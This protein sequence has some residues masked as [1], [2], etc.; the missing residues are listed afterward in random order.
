MSIPRAFLIGIPSV[1]IVYYFSF[2]FIPT[3]TTSTTPALAVG[4]SLTAN[5]GTISIRQDDGSFQDIG[6]IEGDASYQE[7]MKRLSPPSAEHPCPPY[8]D[9]D[10]MWGDQTRQFRRKLRKAIG[11]P[12]SADVGVIATMIKQL[13]ALANAPSTAIISYPALPGLRHEDVSDAASYLGVRIP[14]GNHR[15]PPREV[16]AAYAGHGM[17]L[18]ES[19]DDEEKCRKE[20]LELPVRE[21]LLVEYTEVALLLHASVMREAYDLGDSVSDTAISF[22]LGSSSESSTN[23]DGTEIRDFIVPLLRKRYDHSPRPPKEITVIM[24]G[25]PGSVNSPGV[26]KG[27]KNAL[28][29]LDL[30]AKILTSEPDFIAARGAA[31][32]AWRALSLKTTRGPEE[33]R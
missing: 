22:D 14:E 23:D 33:L 17:G 10:E 13:L 27:V 25:S 3:A 26:Q 6:R 15:F 31:E 5:H 12:A 29:E 24:T 8:T 18:C 21:T 11:L 9:M 20:G 32:L 28:D 2:A 16:A 30:E 1:L 19:Y 4:I 7:M